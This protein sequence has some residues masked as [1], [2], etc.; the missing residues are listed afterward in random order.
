MYRTNVVKHLIGHD[1][2]KIR[3]PDTQMLHI[4]YFHPEVLIDQS[5]IEL[6]VREPGLVAGGA[7]EDTRIC[8][9]F[10]ANTP[11]TEKYLA[12]VIRILDGEGFIV[13]AY[14]TDK[15]KRDKV[16]WRRTS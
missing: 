9:R 4:A 10:F 7:T 16:I 12:V 15:M 14:F 8:Y 1:G 11:V 2:R 3:F 5:K 13:T 6:A